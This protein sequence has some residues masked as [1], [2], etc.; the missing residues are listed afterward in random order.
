MIAHGGGTNG[1]IAYF[2][3]L[4]DEGAVL[5]VL[6]NHQRGAEVV[7]AAAEAFGIRDPERDAIDIDPTE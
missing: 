1:Q 5:T 6:T 2:G 7:N 4:P 3:F